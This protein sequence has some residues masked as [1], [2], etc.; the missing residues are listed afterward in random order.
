[1]DE[2]DEMN[3][4]NLDELLE[5][6]KK[7]VE[8]GRIGYDQGG[9]LV[10]PG[11]EREGYY[12]GKL[13]T[14]KGWPHQGEYALYTKDKGKTVTKYFKNKTAADKWAKKNLPGTGGWN[15]GMVDPSL[16]YTTKGG[17]KVYKS[18]LEYIKKIQSTRKPHY[19][20]RLGWSVFDMNTRKKVSFPNKAAAD[21]FAKKQTIEGEKLIKE[22]REKATKTLYKNEAKYSEALENWT[23]NW[24]KKNGSKFEVR[25]V[26]KAIKQLKKDFTKADITRTK[27]LRRKADVDGFPNIDDAGRQLKKGEA[28]S[29]NSYFRKRFFNAVL[30]HSPE[31]EKRIDQYFK[32]II[33]DKGS[34]EAIQKG[35]YESLEAMKGAHEKMFKNMDDVMFL[36]SQQDTGLYGAGKF[37]FFNKRF[38]N[39]KNYT[40]KVNQSG[41][42][43]LNNI[44]KIEEVLGPQK[45]KQLLNGETS[46]IRFMVN[47]SKDLAELFDV[48]ALPPELRFSIDHNIGIADISRMNKSQIQNSLDSLIGMTLKRN[49]KLGRGGFNARKAKLI[50]NINKGIDVKTNLATLNKLT[51]KAYPET[52]GKNAFKTVAGK[53]EA[54]RSFTFP[55]TQEKLFTDYF[56]EIAQT[57]KGMAAIKK[58]HGSL[59]NL[60]KTLKTAKGPA[61]FK[62]INAV[63]A[64]VG[65]GAAATL[66]AKFGIT[67]V[68][69]D[70]GVEKAKSWP[71]EH[72]WLTGG[73]ATGAAA[74]TKGG[75]NILGKAFRTLGTPLAGLGWA[76]YTAY[77]NL[78]SG[79]SLTESVV[80]PWV[81]MELVFPKLFTE[82]V[83]KITKSPTLQKV[84]GLGKFGSR[85]MPGVGTAI[86]L[87]SLTRDSVRAINKESQRIDAIEDPDQ[88]LAEQDILIRNI[89]GY[90]GGGIAGIRRPWAIPPESGPD[91]QGLA[92]LN[93]YATKRTE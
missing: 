83:A 43:Y 16:K 10:Q 20:K 17:K 31:L 63:I 33:Q 7:N 13:I 52:M 86:T 53:V 65:G 51:A 28:I 75:R 27:G 71:I 39:Y 2:I 12:R 8:G 29:Q 58:Q 70:T 19:S 84:L 66:F 44:K 47:Q 32:Y 68:S 36:L 72:P 45:L 77:D 64:A 90:A 42:T 23:D 60:L 49:I 80:D 91:S 48:K 35:G 62:A 3:K 24:F 34:L 73:V 92:Y 25:N 30:D 1:V 40:Q 57:K 87:G 50:R 5:G 22:A 74:T 81:G 9:Q 55:K 18:Q 14:R 79:K 89:K 37:D 67:P 93:N 56:S 46:I 6:R 61:K 15:I 41:I 38:K 85:V 69:A 26:D 21:K 4:A 76:G 88:Q 78:K 11:P 82:N 59:D 54:T